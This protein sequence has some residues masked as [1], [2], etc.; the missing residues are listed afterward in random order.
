MPGNRHDGG[1]AKA[2]SAFLSVFLINPI[3]GPF[4]CKQSHPRTCP[5][6]AVGL[7]FKKGCVRKRRDIAFHADQAVHRRSVADD[8]FAIAKRA[9]NKRP[10]DGKPPGDEREA[11][12]SNPLAENSYALRVEKRRLK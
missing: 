10:D 5:A 6:G 9:E 4:G 3:S 2:M 11:I 7:R 8:W 12:E 1:H